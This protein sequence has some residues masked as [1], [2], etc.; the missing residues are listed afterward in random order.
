MKEI[1]IIPLARRKM[2]WRG[3]AQSWVNE[4]VRS[5]DQVVQGHGGRLVAQRRRRVRRKERLLRVV[6]E[7]TRD[8]YVVITAYLTSDIKRYWKDKTP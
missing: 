5:P 6:F 1:E 4:A 7:E 3:I 2:A 8:K